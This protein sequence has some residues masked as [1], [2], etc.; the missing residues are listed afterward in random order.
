M[1]QAQTSR[2]T[3]LGNFLVYMDHYDIF[4]CWRKL[5][6]HYD[7]QLIQW[8]PSQQ[9]IVW[10][11][12][13][14]YEVPNFHYSAPEASFSKLGKQINV[15][16]SVNSF[17]KETHN[18]LLTSI[19]SFLDIFQYRMFMEL[20]WSTNI[21]HK[22]STFTMMISGSSYTGSISLKSMLVNLIGASVFRSV[23]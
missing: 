11:V 2:I 23:L 22:F 3:F 7:S 21:F 19:M 16:F 15:P 13:F 5:G 9:D 18:L 12:G 4:C 14:N 20:P 8:L 6:G 1:F 17:P 10:D